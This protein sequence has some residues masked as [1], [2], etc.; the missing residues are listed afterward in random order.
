MARRYA[1]GE[2]HAV[3]VISL[4]DGAL[5]VVPDNRPS[6]VRKLSP[7]Y[8]DAFAADDFTARLKRDSGAMSWG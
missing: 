6:F 2:A 3:L 4:K 8:T 5:Q 7:A 1:S